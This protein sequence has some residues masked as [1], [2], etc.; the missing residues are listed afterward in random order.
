MLKLKDV[1]ARVPYKK[2][3]LYAKIKAG[4]FPNH[5]YLG[6]RGSF[7]IED[8]IE[9]WLRERI[10]VEPNPQTNDEEAA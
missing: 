9:Q 8:E 10:A 6:G 2:S 3:H 5:V 1:L 4:S 7:R